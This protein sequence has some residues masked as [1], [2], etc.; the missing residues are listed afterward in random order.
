MFKSFV[1]ACL[2]FVFIASASAP[3]EADENDGNGVGF[4]IGSMHAGNESG[5]AIMFEFSNHKNNRKFTFQTMEFFGGNYRDL[6][7]LY[8]FARKE[9]SYYTSISAGI[10]FFDDRDDVYDTTGLAYELEA[11][12]LPGRKKKFGF[13]IKLRGSVN[14]TRSFSGIMIGMRYGL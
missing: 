2:I 13:G 7:L 11:G 9:K 5:P 1:Q 3:V 4:S 14:S 6:S 12:L 10:H 8:G